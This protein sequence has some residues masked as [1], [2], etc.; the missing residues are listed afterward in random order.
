MCSSSKSR[1][2]ERSV[3]QGVREGFF[4]TAWTHLLEILLESHFSHGLSDDLLDE[5]LVPLEVEVVHLTEGEALKSLGALEYLEELP[6]VPVSERLR[7]ELSDDGVGLKVRPDCVLN[8]LKRAVLP[9]SARHLLGRGEEA[10]K[11][12]AELARLEKGKAT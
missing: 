10:V 11:L 6:P 8:E 9:H 2:P 4:A 3:S 7:L 12:L 1:G 5:N